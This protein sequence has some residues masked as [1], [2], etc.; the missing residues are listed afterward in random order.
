[1]DVY[2]RAL[3]G[4]EVA[5]AEGGPIPIPARKARAL[6]AVLARR[7]GVPHA[8]DV[9]AAMLWPDS[10]EPQAR[11]SLRQA[12]KA[13]RRDLGDAGPVAI[14]TE[15]DGL[16][17]NPAAAEVDILAFERLSGADS[18]DALDRAADL[19]RGDLLAGV[20]PP[21][22]AF[23]EWLLYERAG[24]R[25]RAVHALSKLVALH[26]D[27]EPAARAAV[28]LLALD[29]LQERVHRLLM[30]LYLDQ[31]RRGDALE[32][33]QRCRDVLQRE[34]GVI[35]EAETERLYREIRGQPAP[36][37]AAATA[38]PI[39]GRPAVAVLPFRNLSGDPEQ[40]YF[41]DGLSEDIITA[42]T[43][44]RSF[45][46]IASN[47]TFAY[48]DQPVDIKQA[49]HA[50]DARY[51]LEG[52]TRREGR[53]VRV[54]AQLIDGEG[55]HHIWAE[56][57][58]R[59]LD[60]IFEVQDDI[61]YRIV[62]TVAP[63]L[64][65]AEFKRAAAKRP[66]D[67]DAWD[68]VLRGMALIYRRTTEGN[69]EARQ[70]FERAIAIEPGYADAH[71]GLAMS[72]NYAILFD[73]PADREALAKKALAAARDAV[74]CD[75]SSAV[76]HQELS[77]AYQWLDRHQDALAEIRIAVDL[78]PYDAVGLHQLGNKS[79]LAGD[80]AGISYMERA[81][82]LNPLDVQ[83]PARLTFLA[84]AYFNIGADDDAVDR[85]RQAIQRRADYPHAHFILAL[86]L[87]R[88][89]RLDEA[90][91]ALARCDELHPGF[92]ESRRDWHPYVDPESNRRLQEALREVMA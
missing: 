43:R 38:D 30:R 59:A 55:G 64:A 74:R 9:L 57:Y 83:L 46:V 18:A 3:G 37:A 56:S 8:R 62:A 11:A 73:T 2:V 80:P 61:T 88:L 36:A 76:A 24:L 48:K 39:L 58:D 75:E 44:W 15:G 23:A 41:A 13:L 69:A 90:R 42:L 14:A 16:A 72:Y 85:A 71:A 20:V 47:S 35:P 4:F 50:L 51:L 49:A 27:G 12:L 54:T 68:C 40:T 67:L 5:G 92:V 91:A 66:E 53:R 52:S 79:D 45:P 81:Q 25:E 26:G 34:I 7:P 84:R 89:G 86:A 10:A 32:Q 22:E 21:T 31:G 1:M 87:G 29:P 82:R 78:N 63:R 60:D 6:L 77:T 28:R 65:K 19:Y 17:L 33:Y 70:W